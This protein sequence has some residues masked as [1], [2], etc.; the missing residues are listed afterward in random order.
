MIKKTVSILRRCYIF[1]RYL[2]YR[3]VL[4]RYY[5]NYKLAKGLT[6][7]KVFSQKETLFGYYNLSPENKKGEVLGCDFTKKPIVDILLK[8]NGTTSIIGQTQAFNYQQGSMLQWSFKE[9][10]LLYYNSFNKERKDYECICYDTEKHCC[11]DTLPKPVCCISRDGRYALSLN[12]E[13][14]AIMRP[15]YGYF[16]NEGGDLPGMQDD[17]IWK[18]DF[19]TKKVR[20]IITLKQL[21]E[22]NYVDTMEGAEH[23]VNHIDISPNGNRFMFLHRWVGP[24]GR[25]MR[26]ITADENGE[27]LYILNGDKMTSHSCWYDNSRIISFCYTSEYGNAY[28][29][30]IDQTKQ[31]ELLSA[32]LPTEDGHPSVSPDKKWLITDSYPGLHRMST[33]YLYNFESKSVFAIG[34]FY[35]PIKYTGTERIDLHPK[36]NLS[37]DKIYFE[38]GHNG[39]R[40]LYCLH[41]DKMTH[42]E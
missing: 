27:N 23:K 26:L 14:L 20:L 33:L 8:Q 40:N 38:S 42:E 31:K 34:R 22:Y 18:I 3:Y 28:T 5:A 4:K 35:Q 30:F 19:Q 2:V 16:C 11:A 37:G 15:D 6:I 24:K 32:D 36:W 9:D 1:F 13:R 41:I 17:G 10:N 39:F 25:F 12:F 29:S 7:E 21:K